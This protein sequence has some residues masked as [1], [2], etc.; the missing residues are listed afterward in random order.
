MARNMHEKF[1]LVVFSFHFRWLGVQMSSRQQRLIIVN[2]T[3]LAVVINVAA[4]LKT[5][6]F[7]LNRLR[8]QV[9]NAELRHR[10]PKP[11]PPG[12]LEPKAA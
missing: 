8:E 4:N 11:L 6:L 12:W 1:R 7:E 10:G 3:R 9:R 5:Q 2:N